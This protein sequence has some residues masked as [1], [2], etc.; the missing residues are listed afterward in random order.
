MSHPITDWADLREA[1]RKA[2]FRRLQ[3]IDARWYPGGASY[4]RIG[5]DGYS[6]M[7]VDGSVSTSR[8]L[9]PRKRLRVVLRGPVTPH[10]EVLVGPTPAEVLAAAQRLGIGGAW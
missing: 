8:N 5:A 9:G 1:A 4:F 2:G 6:H 3:S 10:G 7:D